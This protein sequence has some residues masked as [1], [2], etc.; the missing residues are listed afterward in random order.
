M[1][2]IALSQG[3]RTNLQ[4]L[5]GISDML[6][7][8]QERLATGR[9]V[10]SAL[11]NPSNFFQAKGMS[12]RAQTLTSR[13]D[14]MSNGVQTLK[15][16]DNAI[17]S[18]TKM[19]ESAR[20]LAEQSLNESVQGGQ[21][22]TSTNAITNGTTG[23]TPRERA[24]SATLVAN[25]LDA[26]DRITLTRSKGGVT[27]QLQLEV[28]GAA[29]NGVATVEDLVNRVNESGFA[30]ARVNDN[31]T[32]EFFSAID[33]DVAADTFA[34]TFTTDADAAIAL[35]VLGFTAALT[36]GNLTEGARVASSTGPDNSA[37]IA[38]F[39]SQFDRFRADAGF[40][41]INLLADGELNVIFN[42]DRTSSLKV[43]GS[44]FTQSGLGITSFS[45]A[46]ADTFITQMDAAIGTMK[47][48]QTSLGNNMTVVQERQRFTNALNDVLRVGADKLTLADQNEE[49]ANVLALQTRQQLAQSA[50]SLANQADQ[51]VLQLLR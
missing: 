9:R 28:G 6:A 51:A 15:A 40:N 7:S 16:A 29:P 30:N 23:D 32:L 45:A 31:G 35:P 3:V 25:G 37:A 42:E 22:Y 20:T 38:D 17:T 49:A 44:D 4:S 2:D 19:L 33:V 50:L 11:D 43:T 26:T 34:I 41:G 21:R 13:L 5:R 47:A 39:L 8:S 14:G 36:A 10:N 27:E 48:T 18:M 24:L 46:T 12:D 1:S